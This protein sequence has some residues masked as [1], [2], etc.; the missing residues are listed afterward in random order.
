MAGLDL[1]TTQGSFPSPLQPEG[2][3]QTGGPKQKDARMEDASHQFEASLMH[4]LFQPLTEKD[5]LFADEPDGSG[6]GEDGE[7]SSPLGAFASEAMAR[8]VADH[9]GFGIAR[10]LIDHF[11]D[12]ETKTAAFG[13][14][15]S[16]SPSSRR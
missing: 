11:R 15:G 12:L 2:M 1:A 9:G 13:S 5:P 10:Q 4:E 8:A 6:G 7:S 14:F 3:D 16:S